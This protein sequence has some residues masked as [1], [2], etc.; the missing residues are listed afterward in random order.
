MKITILDAHETLFEGIVSEATLP[1]TDGEMT[2]MDD[3]EPLFLVLGR[4]AIAL[5]SR[6][7]LVGQRLPGSGGVPPL[8]IRRGL[9]RMRANELLVLVE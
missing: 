1:A 2:L 6:S 9:A 3:H 8:R 7:R 5:K 4:G